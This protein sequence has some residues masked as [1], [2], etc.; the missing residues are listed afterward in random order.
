VGGGD[1]RAAE[2]GEGVRALKSA[3]VL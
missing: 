1:R 3:H 2:G